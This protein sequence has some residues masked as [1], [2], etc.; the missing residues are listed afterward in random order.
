MSRK[1]SCELTLTD[2][3]RIEGILDFMAACELPVA[4]REAVITIK[5]I[6]RSKSA[7]RSKTLYPIWDGKSAGGGTFERGE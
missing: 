1:G 3:V 5:T 7:R 4:R 2:I 6:L